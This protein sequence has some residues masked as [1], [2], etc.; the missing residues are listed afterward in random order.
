MED[1]EIKTDLD[2]LCIVMKKP[3]DQRT[4]ADVDLI[5]SLV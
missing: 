3:F 5:E 4:D 2:R 1:Y